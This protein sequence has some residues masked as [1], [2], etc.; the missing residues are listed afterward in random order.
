VLVMLKLAPFRGYPKKHDNQEI[1]ML[2]FDQA[3]KLILDSVKPLDPIKLPLLDALSMVASEPV[4]AGL[5]L[6]SFDNSAMDGYA[7]RSVEC[8]DAGE[9]PVSTTI[10]AGDRA[11][12]EFPEG[13]V[14]KIMTGAPIPPGFDAVVPFE[15]VV[16]ED[17]D[18]VILPAA[19]KPGQH[20]RFSGE[21]IRSGDCIASAG[22]IIRPAEISM[23]AASG[24]LSLKVHRRVRVAIL[25]TGD[26]LVEPCESIPQGKII[27]SNSPGLAA[28]VLEAGGE[29]VMLGIAADT[30]GSLAAKI[31]AG[32]QYDM[33]VT[34]AG[35]SAGERDLVREMLAEAGV[36]QLFW[37]IDLKPGGPTAFGLKGNKP[38]FSL[39]G[40][41]VSSLLTFE[42][43]V[44]P[45]LLRMM[46]HTAVLRPH[47]KGVLEE[48]V[49]KKAGKANLLRAR[50]RKDGDVFRLSS[51][52]NQQT[53]IQRTLLYADA[54]CFLPSETTLLKKGELV[55]FHF[56]HDSAMMMTVES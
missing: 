43:L 39:P 8:I 18:K 5:D 44:R 35:V 9:K 21:D 12:R 29:P 40:N 48:D 1:E 56:M 11:D 22:R 23:L 13:T 26:E 27:N 33:L 53:G 36:K 16:Y 15:E 2:A 25:S 10:M 3:R 49:S 46:G 38:V 14:V 45:A 41:P 37:K 28:A 42:E 7:V 51:A 52:G 17:A 54:V 19:V 20:I 6:P 24:I 30:R 4:S 50:V 34:T 32:L 31:A 55:D 47:F